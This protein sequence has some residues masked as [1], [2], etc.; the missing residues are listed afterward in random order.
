M[1]QSTASAYGNMT[2]G[3]KQVTTG[4]NFGIIADFNTTVP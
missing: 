1:N 3:V 4:S 2:T